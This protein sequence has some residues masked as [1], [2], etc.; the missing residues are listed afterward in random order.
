MDDFDYTTNRPQDGARPA[1][2]AA[3]AP[4]WLVRAME[5]FADHSLPND[6]FNLRGQ[7]AE[8]RM[9]LQRIEEHRQKGLI[10]ARDLRELEEGFAKACADPHG[11]PML[12]LESIYLQ[13]YYRRQP[14]RR[15][16]QYNTGA[17]P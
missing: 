17:A 13:Q 8:Y 7:Y 1:P 9:F 15:A 14:A 16:T 3:D 11:D 10:P 6:E 12:A 4:S 5:L 2:I